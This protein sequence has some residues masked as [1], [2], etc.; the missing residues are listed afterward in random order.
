MILNYLK[1]LIQWFE[2]LIEISFITKSDHLSIMEHKP[3]KRSKNRFSKEEDKKL[4]HLVAIHGEK[5]WKLISQEMNNRCC[6]QCRDRYFNYLSPNVKK[7]KWSTSEDRMLAEL[8]RKIGPKWSKIASKFKG[9]T[10]SSIKNRWNFTIGRYLQVSLDENNCL[11]EIGESPENS[12]PQETVPSPTKNIKQQLPKQNGPKA[13]KYSVSEIENVASPQPITSKRESINQQDPSYSF[14]QYTENSMSAA[15]GIMFDQIPSIPSNDI[16][17]SINL[18]CTYGSTDSYSSNTNLSLSTENLGNV[19][20]QKNNA[21]LQMH[22]SEDVK[23]IATSNTEISDADLNALLLFDKI[24]GLSQWD[25]L[26][27]MFDD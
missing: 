9:R 14:S 6:R 20:T 22:Q 2:Y 10:A 19:E 24:D 18:S 13:Q 25:A 4:L 1:K 23:T 16:L 21:N 27:S 12:S 8:Y 11:Q 5:N 3:Y 17:P 15:P 26:C 7:G